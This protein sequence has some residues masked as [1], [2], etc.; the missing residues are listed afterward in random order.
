MLIAVD[1][2]GTKTL[3]ASFES[4]GQIHNKIKFQTPRQESEYV[5]MVVET[6]KLLSLNSTIDAVSIA[7]PGVIRDDIIVWCQNLG[8]ENFDLISTIKNHFPDTPVMM[9]NDAN[10]GGLGETRLL[11]DDPQSSLYVTVSTGIGTGLIT[12]GQINQGMRHSE[13]GHS[14]VEFQDVVRTW[15]SFASGQA[16]FKTFGKFGKDIHDKETWDEIADRISRGFLALVPMI[17]PDVIIIGGSM[18]SHFP[19][20]SDRLTELLSEKLPKKIVKFP[21]LIKAVHP[22]EAVIFGCYYYALDCLAD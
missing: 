22:E 12:N 16:I 10:L 4:D 3:V 20:Y 13:G 2:G 21:R 6:I 7:I 17:Q 9:E 8:W 11:E 15:E 1:T 5:K 14:L 19:K 18:G